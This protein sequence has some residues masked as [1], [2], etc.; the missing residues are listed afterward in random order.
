LLIF[1]NLRKGRGFA[2]SRRSNVILA[3]EI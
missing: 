2:W 1:E 3:F